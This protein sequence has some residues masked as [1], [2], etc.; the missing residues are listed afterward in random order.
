MSEPRYYVRNRGAVFGPYSLAEIRKLVNR[1]V[2]QDFTGFSSNPADPKSW[3]AAQTIRGLFVDQSPDQPPGTF[4]GCQNPGASGEEPAHWHD[5]TSVPETAGPVSTENLKSQISKG[6][7]APDVLVWREGF[8][9][10]QPASTLPEFSSVGPLKPSELSLTERL[11][12]DRIYREGGLRTMASPHVHYDDP[13]C[14][15]EGCDQ[16]M[17]WIDF[18]LEP[19]GE[20]EKIYK[21]LVTSWWSGPGFVGRCPR[22]QGWVR[23]STLGTEAVD[24]P[25]KAGLPRLPDRW[26]EVAQIA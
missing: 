23:F 11:E 3:V 2:L 22:C 12:L 15:R 21:P 20:P 9:A 25:E 16:Q 24:D 1:G 5:P 18:K 14:P 26:H 7:L 6:L 4:E 17:E 8:D 19:H 13:N 10:W